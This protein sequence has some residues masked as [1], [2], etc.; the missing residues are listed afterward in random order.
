VTSAPELPRFYDQLAEWWP[1]FS[2]PIHYGEEA[3]DL[4]ARLE[5]VSRSGF[6]T[7]LELGSGGGSLASHLKPHF[8]LTLTDRSP[9]MLAVS[10]A[11]NPE[12][13][14][15][16]G[17]MRTLRLNRTFDVVLVHDAIMYATTEADV[18]ATIE[19]AAAHVRPG[20]TVLVVPDFTKE[21]FTPG[22]EHGGEDGTDGRGLRYL[23][24]HWDPDSADDT[25]LVDY[26]FLLREA[27]GDVRA[28]HDRHVEG[29]FTRAQWLSWFAAAGMPATSDLD[30][31]CR[32]VFLAHP[33]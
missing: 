24:W 13:E 26:A 16:A 3:A 20:G 32:D 6:A 15:L 5:P 33:A 8:L 18:R 25:Y 30:P 10:R 11:V 29:L 21:T 22:T 1:L 9:G 12:A 28:V 31:W 4:L 17:D 7:L 23:E 14:H 27:T 19:T 2:P